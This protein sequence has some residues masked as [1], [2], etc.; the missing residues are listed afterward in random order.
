MNSC[1]CIIFLCIDK[2]FH[3]ILRIGLVRCSNLNLNQK[4]LNFVQSL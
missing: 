3:F 4:D 1:R 2:C